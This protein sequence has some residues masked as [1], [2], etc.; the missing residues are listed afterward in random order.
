VLIP[1]PLSI[2]DVSFSKAVAGLF[3]INFE[4]NIYCIWGMDEQLVTKQ[5]KNIPRLFSS[6]LLSKIQ[7][8]KSNFSSPNAE[9]CFDKLYQKESVQCL[10]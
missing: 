6:G 10:L 3:D 8:K 7:T 2:P 9:N 5:V 4:V 1:D